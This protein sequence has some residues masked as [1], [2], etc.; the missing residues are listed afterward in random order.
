MDTAYVD[1]NGK[2][3]LDYAKASGG[4]STQELLEAAARQTRNAARSADADRRDV[5]ASPTEDAPNTERAPVPD[6]AALPQSVKDAIAHLQERS[7]GE[8][9]WTNGFTLLHFAAMVGHAELC[10]YF[11]ELRAD[12]S[13]KDGWPLHYNLNYSVFTLS[14]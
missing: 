14:F 2:T 9:A 7:W 6:L 10:A 5:L 3:A 11:L 4:S 8:M 1:S 12:P 13:E